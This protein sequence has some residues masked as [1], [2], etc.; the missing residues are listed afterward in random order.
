MTFKGKTILVTG[1]SHGI[2]KQCVRTLLEQGA[3]SI[4]LTGRNIESLHATIEEL[5]SLGFEHTKMQAFVCDQA[6]KS[7]IDTL[8]NNLKRINGDLPSLVIANVGDNPV[9]RLGAKKVHN[10]DYD[11]VEQCFRTNTLHTFYL[12]SHLLDT[13]RRTRFGRIVLV[14]TQAYQ[15]GIPGQLAYNL[16][17]SALVGLKNTIVSEYGKAGI[18]CHL[19]NPGV[20]EN[21]RTEKLREKI[22]GLQVVSEKQVANT[23][24]EALSLNENVHNG[25]ELSI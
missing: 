16:S 24:V 19:V 20:V 5:E 15:Q 23:V 14:G 18:Y 11:S 4:V 22:S 10:T 6:E 7:D 2:G 12:L 3:D 21:A 8:I 25:L 9:H 1:S 17:K 13:M